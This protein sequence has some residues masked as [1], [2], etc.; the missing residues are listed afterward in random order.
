MVLLEIND[1]CEWLEFEDVDEALHDY[2]ETIKLFEGETL[3]ESF[4]LDCLYPT[5]F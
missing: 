1:V 2:F 4:S 5:S 3:L